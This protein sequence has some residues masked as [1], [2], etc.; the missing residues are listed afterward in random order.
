MTP[1]P[2]SS[3]RRWPLLLL[4]LLPLCAAG[5]GSW[6][7]WQRLQSAMTTLEQEDALIQRLSRQLNQLEASH[8][9]HSQRL[10]DAEGSTSSLA[11]DVHSLMAA[12]AAADA[13][14]TQL[15][16]RL[17]DGRLVLQSA[18]Q[19]LQLAAD[20]AA[21]AQDRN[22]ALAA[23]D[24]AD[25]R[26][27][28]LG[29]SRLLAIRKQL[30]EDRQALAAVAVP[31]IAGAVLS[32][33]GLL[34]READLPLAVRP[35]QHFEAPPAAPV[36]PVQGDW[37]E[38]AWAQL[39]VALNAVVRIKKETQ[40]VNALLPAEQE[41]LIRHLLVL[42]LEATRLAVLR[43][44]IPAARDAAQAASQW[45]ARYYR[46][47]DPGVAAANSALERLQALPAQAQLPVP[48]QALAALKKLNGL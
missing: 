38:R 18:E 33:G 48:L 39:R 34:A 21:L 4:L 42:R 17:S 14:L 8:A 10:S 37:A 40:P 28:T 36:T 20:S 11:S 30:A 19:L 22:T 1:S 32:L 2:P 43:G 24:A 5:Y 35:P 13:R 41:T 7:L 12:Q 29:D 3:P 9:D 26:L 31:D 16:D 6:K 15:A 25:A 47:E 23:L 27:A 46:A 44:Q 45:L